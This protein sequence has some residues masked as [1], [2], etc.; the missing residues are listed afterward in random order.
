MKHLIVF[1]L[2]LPVIVAT[3]QEEIFIT[4]NIN[5]YF[6]YTEGGGPILLVGSDEVSK[7]KFFFGGFGIGATAIKK[8]PG[9]LNLKAAGNLSR[10]TYRNASIR[11][12]DNNNVPLGEY[13]SHSNDYLL[14]ILGMGRY[15]ATE[16]FHL[17]AG[18][19]FD[20]MLVSLIRNPVGDFSG[21]EVKN[22]VRNRNF[23]PFVPIFPVELSIKK[24]KAFYTLRY[25]QALLNKF[26]G[27]LAKTAKTSYGVILFEVGIKI[28]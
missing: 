12:T 26:R 17:G 13:T 16:K 4:A 1:I 10:H 15:A 7:Q 6:P 3:A 23:K 2:L 20:F 11:M 25:E 18:I 14:S 27:D 19:G 9:K 21:R 22:S 5:S 28:K 8:L 24:P